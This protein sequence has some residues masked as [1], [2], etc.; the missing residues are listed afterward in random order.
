MR[1][2]GLRGGEREREREG[3]REVG[4]RDRER[5]RERGVSERPRGEGERD[6]ERALCLLDCVWEGGRGTLSVSGVVGEDGRC[7]RRSAEFAIYDVV[8]LAQGYLGFKCLNPGKYP[9]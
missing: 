7:R 1:E 3:E 2:R 9:Q 6:G 8:F 4:L 5:E